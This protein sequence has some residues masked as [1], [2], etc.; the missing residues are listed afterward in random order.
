MSKVKK[1]D[2]QE[3]VEDQGGSLVKLTNGNY[4]IRKGD[5]SINIGK[6]D[7]SNKWAEAQLRR[8]WGDATGIPKPDWL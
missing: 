8:A 5:K 3:Y 2:L 7:S 6:P 4:N 1:S